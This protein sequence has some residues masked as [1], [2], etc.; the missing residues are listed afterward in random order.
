MRRPSFSTVFWI[1][2]LC[3]AVNYARKSSHRF[4]SRVSGIIDPSGNPIVNMKKAQSFYP[5]LLSEKNLAVSWL[6]SSPLEPECKAFAEKVES[7]ELNGYQDKKGSHF[8]FYRDLPK[9]MGSCSIDSEDYQWAEKNYYQKCFSNNPS[10]LSGVE[11]PCLEALLLLRATVTA[12]LYSRHT[13]AELNG[14]PE[15]ADL[16][17]LAWILPSQKGGGIRFEKLNQFSARMIDLESGVKLPY[18]A[19]FIARLD[20]WPAFKQRH[21]LMEQQKF[22]AEMNDLALELKGVQTE[23]YSNMLIAVETHGFE[24]SLLSR[25]AAQLAGTKSNLAKAEFL[26]ALALWKLTQVEDSLNAVVSAMRLEPENRVY[27]EAFQSLSV[28]GAGEE[29]FLSA[30]KVDL[31]AEDFENL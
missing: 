19:K 30:L 25:Y 24:P 4:V 10:S 14:A 29:V 15:I 26:K 28:A 13:D 8:L 9:V 16:L 18:K 21:P 5:F 2:L 6:Q 17:Y 3:I 27:R 11:K 22:W 12:V 31:T 20:E 23:V 7:L 1:I